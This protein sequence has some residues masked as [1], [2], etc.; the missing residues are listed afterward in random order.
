MRGVN[1]NLK[2]IQISISS[3]Y[4]WVPFTTESAQW[5][6]LFPVIP[7]RT[8]LVT[9]VHTFGSV[10]GDLGAIASL[11][12]LYKDEFWGLILWNA[13]CLGEFLPSP[14][15]L[16]WVLTT[17]PGKILRGQIPVPSLKG[18]LFWCSTHPSSSLYLTFFTPVS[19]WIQM[20]TAQSLQM[21]A[22]RGFP[23]TWGT[24]GLKVKGDTEKWIKTKPFFSLT[25]NNFIYFNWRIITLQHCDS[26]CRT[27]AWISHSHAYVPSLLNSLPPPT[28]PH[29]WS[30]V[31]LVNRLQIP[32]AVTSVMCY[33]TRFS[34]WVIFRA[35]FSFP[36][37]YQAVKGW[38]SLT[39]RW[40]SSESW[41]VLKPFKAT[42]TWRSSSS[43]ETPVLTLTATDSSWWQ[44]F[45]S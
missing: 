41:A 9:F 2:L 17:V 19:N 43:W 42:S 29:P 44:L 38:Q 10:L 27:S 5:L 11:W 24:Q 16:R 37:S 45:S 40:I 8:T 4:L 18:R 26:F 12:W 7:L 3:G 6:I 28:P 20:S 13:F 1:S 23:S 21:W 35:L 30:A 32:A 14:F 15:V 36:F 25:L 22:G 34:I 33:C 39:W 31:Q